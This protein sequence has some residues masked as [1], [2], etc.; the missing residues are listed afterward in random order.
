MAAAEFVGIFMACLGLAKGYPLVSFFF[1]CFPLSCFLGIWQLI[2][3]V[4][5]AANSTHGNDIQLVWSLTRGFS[6][7][8]F[9]LDVEV[10]RSIIGFD[11][12]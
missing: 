10:P 11:R 8:L 2:R 3:R 6:F 1:F 7:P 4:I 9:F 12:T 5:K